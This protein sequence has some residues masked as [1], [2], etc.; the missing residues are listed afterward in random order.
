MRRLQAVQ[1]QLL[2]I[3]VANNVTIVTCIHCIT[4]NCDDVAVFVGGR[5][6]FCCGRSSHWVAIRTRLFPSRNCLNCCVTDIAWKNH[7]TP[8]S[9]CTP[10]C[11]VASPLGIVYRE[12]LCFT[13]VAFLLTFSHHLERCRNHTAQH[14]RTGK[15]SL[16]RGIIALHFCKNYASLPSI[17][18]EEAWRTR[19][20]S[21]IS[22][23]RY[24]F[25][26][27]HQMAPLPSRLSAAMENDVIA[28]S[29]FMRN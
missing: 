13:S 11:I 4:G 24:R 1:V 15:Y 18:L 23:R 7:P 12:D 28:A 21:F 14:L 29:C 20:T 6:A 5:M 27:V 26:I 19:C 3:S 25:T 17:S 9:R 16:E 22:E 8:R 2:Y 10:C